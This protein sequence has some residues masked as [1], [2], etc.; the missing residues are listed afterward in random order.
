MLIRDGLFQNFHNLQEKIR[1]EWVQM[2][3][4]EACVFCMP[5]PLRV[6]LARAPMNHKLFLMIYGNQKI[7]TVPLT[8]PQISA[9]I[10]HVEN[11]IV[12]DAGVVQW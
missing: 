12:S 11:F 5:I 7:P 10:N 6:C 1:W 2:C 4:Y 8:H 3:G 9:N